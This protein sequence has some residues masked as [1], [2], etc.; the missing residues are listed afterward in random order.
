MQLLKLEEPETCRLL[1]AY[2]LGLNRHFLNIFAATLFWLP[3]QL[4]APTANKLRWKGSGCNCSACLRLSPAAS[5]DFECIMMSDDDRMHQHPVC[6]LYSD[7][8]RKC[9]FVLLNK[10]LLQVKYDKYCRFQS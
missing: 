7:A 3:L 6:V 5:F 4:P 10:E 9:F 8:F 2:C 1:V